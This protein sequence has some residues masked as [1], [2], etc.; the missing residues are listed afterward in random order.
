MR[1][2]ALALAAT[3]FA[4]IAEAQAPLPPPLYQIPVP[5]YGKLSTATA[6][7]TASVI[8]ANFNPYDVTVSWVGAFPYGDARCTAARYMT[9]TLHAGESAAYTGPDCTGLAALALESTGPLGMTVS[10]HGGTGPYD[11][12]VSEQ[13]ATAIPTWFPAGASAVLPAMPLTT[14]GTRNLFFFSQSTSEVTVRVTESR[15][16]F[17]PHVQTFTV[18][19]STLQILPLPF[20]SN[21][22]G[23]DVGFPEPLPSVLVEADAPFYVAASS[24]LNPARPTLRLPFRL[25][26]P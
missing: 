14:T 12:T 26:S 4:A 19:G 21:F 13:S 17:E 20:A 7:Y 5:L 2:A 22:C 10:V 16:C 11:I 24:T 6:N 8:L 25:P 18:A 3:L 1:H 9:T 15:V 23:G